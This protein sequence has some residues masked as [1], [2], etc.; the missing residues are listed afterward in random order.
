VLPSGLHPEEDRYI[1]IMVAKI[2]GNDCQRG[3]G[4]TNSGTA[5]HT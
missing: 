3:D 4:Y 2:P 5:G 1:D